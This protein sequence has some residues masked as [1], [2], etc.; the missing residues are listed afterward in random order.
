M[1]LPKSVIA[2]VLLAM[3]VSA[4]ETPVPAR[5]FPEISFKHKTPY[6]IDV[7]A[8][9]IE[10][11]PQ[12]PPAKGTLVKELPVP[13]TVVAEA[14]AAQ[15]LQAVGKSGT[16]VVRIEKAEM[17]EEKLKKTGGIKGAFTTDQTE[18]YSG[19]LQVSVSIADIRGL[20]L[21]RAGA[22]RSRTIAEDATLAEREKLWFSMVESLGRDMDA[23]MDRQIPKHLSGYL[24]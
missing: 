17:V 14:W 20:A 18:R 7:E 22:T 21:A 5:N 9:E 3:A 10:V 4:C 1:N 13:L 16:A 24:R 23:E 6:K 8:V 19:Q 11:M 15:R 2:I 12:T